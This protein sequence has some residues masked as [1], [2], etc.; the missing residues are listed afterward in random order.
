[1]LRLFKNDRLA[2]ACKAIENNDLDRLQKLLPKI[3][4]S[5][6]DQPLSDQTPPLA[7]LCILQQSPKALKQVLAR[8]A[9]P[10][11]ICSSQPGISRPQLAIQQQQSLSLLSALFSAGAR[12]EPQTLI[13]DCFE[14]EKGE[15]LMLHLSLLLQQG[16]RADEGLVHRALASGQLPLIHFVIHSGAEMPENLDQ[17][18]YPAE[19]L[20]YARRCWDDIKIRQ[21]FL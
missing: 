7:E 3:P 20:N 11:L 14:S 21:M 16:A 5:E 15:E 12:T 6:I 18:N 1:M 19:V 9:D 10:D 13:A 4:T 2:K 17:Q 8:G